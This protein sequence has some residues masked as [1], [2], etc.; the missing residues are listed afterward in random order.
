MKEKLNFKETDKEIIEGEKNHNYEYYEFTE[1]KVLEII[2]KNINDV[3]NNDWR[4]LIQ[5][6]FPKSLI[7]SG[8]F[9]PILIFDIEDGFRIDPPKYAFDDI[10]SCSKKDDIPLLLKIYNFLIENE[11]KT[12]DKS[13]LETIR[14]LKDNDNA[15]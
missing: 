11:V 6:I 7:A 3:T 4:S 10:C 1:K 9:Q 5:M 14:K 12:F 13:W 8:L 2:S 15:N